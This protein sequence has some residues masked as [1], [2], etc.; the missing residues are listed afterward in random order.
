LELLLAD[1]E[2]RQSAVADFARELFSVADNLQRALAAIGEEARRGVADRRRRSRLLTLE[3][4]RF[5]VRPI[6]ALGKRFDPTCTKRWRR[7]RA[8]KRPE[9]SSAPSRMD[10]RST[11]ACGRRP[12]S[13]KSPAECRVA[14][15]RAGTAG[16]TKVA[17]W[18]T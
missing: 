11:A 2:T 15:D 8:R 5:R 7:K 17:E 12:A 13:C 9:P 3:F 18:R 1:G 14:L 4:E 10:T 6:E 16:G